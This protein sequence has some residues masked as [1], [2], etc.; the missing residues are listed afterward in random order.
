MKIKNKTT[1]SKLYFI[2]VTVAII[3]SAMSCSKSSTGNNTNVFSGT[4]YGS[5]VIGSYSEDD[6]VTIPSTTSVNI[7]INSKTEQG[8]TYSINGTVSGTTVN[9]PSQQV[10]VTGLNSTYTVSG[11]GSLN[12]N[13]ALVLN[14]TFVGSS[15]THLTFTGTKH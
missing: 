12:N 13:S 11:S 8:S 7:V 14:Y 9:I 5:L 10:Y 6:T 4:Y 2:I 15:T 3:V 1:I